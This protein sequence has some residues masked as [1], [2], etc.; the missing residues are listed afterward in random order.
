MPVDKNFFVA[1]IWVSTVLQSNWP[2]LNA[3]VD[4]V[5]VSS[6]EATADAVRQLAK[7]NHLVVEGAGAAALAAAH[8]PFFTGKRVVAVL[9]GAVSITTFWRRS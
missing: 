2:F 4:G 7:H 5:V 1:S 9:S 8:H 3:M 6:L